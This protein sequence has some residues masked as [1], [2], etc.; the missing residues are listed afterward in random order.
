MKITTFDPIIVTTKFD[1]A[2]EVFE[3]LG[4]EKTHAPVTDT[5][6]KDVQC[7]RMK[8]ADGFHVDVADV[9]D[10]PRDMEYIRINVDDFDA[11]YEIFMKHGFTNPRGDGTIDQKSSK[12]A[13]LFSPSGYRVALVQHI[14]NHD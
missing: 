9:P 5:G 13:S 8:N 6:E 12:T 14:K 3:S 1:D 10:I 2:V 7:Y 4:F 11:A